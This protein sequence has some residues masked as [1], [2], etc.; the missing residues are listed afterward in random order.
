MLCYVMLCYAMVCYAVLFYVILYF[1][2]SL[3]YVMEYTICN[4]VA[5]QQTKDF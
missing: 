5:D 1:I 3:H 2:S 4:M